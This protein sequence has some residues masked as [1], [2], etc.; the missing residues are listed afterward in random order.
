MGNTETTAKDPFIRKDHKAYLDG[1]KKSGRTNMFGATP[2]IMRHFG[3]DKIEAR[4]IVLNW[5]AS[6]KEN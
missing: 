1:L 3:V 5:M 2:Y 4:E 6:N